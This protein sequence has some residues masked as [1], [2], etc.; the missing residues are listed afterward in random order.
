M[1]DTAEG[2]LAVDGLTAL[3][4]GEE[5]TP[6]QLSAIQLLLRLTRP[7]PLVHRGRPDD[8]PSGEHVRVFPSWPVFQASVTCLPFVGRIDRASPGKLDSTAIGTGILIAPR[9]FL[10]NRHVLQQLSRGTE[11]LEEGQGV[12]RFRWEEGAFDDDFCIIAGVAAVHATAD[13]ALLRLAADPPRIPEMFPAVDTGG[14]A[15]NDDVVAAGYPVDDPLRNPLFLRN[16][17]GTT[18]GV[19]RVAPGQCTATFA[20]GFHHDC[21]TLGGNSG[22]PMLSLASGRVIGLHASGGFLWKNEAVAGATIAEFLAAHAANS[23]TVCL[24]GR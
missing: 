7:A 11:R 24:P 18:F 16:I 20:G 1:P 12:V 8:M 14:A 6:A 13:L 17:F 3:R 5:P 2:R 19:L 4:N 15:P 10:T 9:L 22:S 23:P 21:T